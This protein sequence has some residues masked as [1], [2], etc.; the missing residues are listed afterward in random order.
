[1]TLT[2]WGAYHRLVRPLE[3]RS[4]A[5]HVSIDPAA[6][7]V[8]VID[9]EGLVANGKARVRWR[10][11]GR[12]VDYRMD[13]LDDRG[14]PCRLELGQR[15]EGFSLSAWTELAGTLRGHGAAAWGNA[16]VRVDYRDLE[17]STLFEA[18]R[19]A[20]KIIQ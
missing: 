4:L 3:Q 18:V 6:D 19:L 2:L 13:F 11:S 17:P 12:T 7:I 8:A 15:C 10:R 1:M 9:A 20:A 14:E 5:V 16:R